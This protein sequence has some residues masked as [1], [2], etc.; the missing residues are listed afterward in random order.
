MDMAA[1]ESHSLKATKKT[2][3]RLRQ[4]ASA[5]MMAAKTTF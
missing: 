3:K 2:L 5:T 1:K 4:D